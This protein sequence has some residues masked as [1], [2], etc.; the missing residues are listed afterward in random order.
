MRS[1]PKRLLV[2]LSISIFMVS[3][4]FLFGPLNVY[5]GNITEFSV[6]LITTLSFF[7]IPALILVFVS[8][9]VGLL[10]PEKLYS[11]Y[12]S[13]LFMFGVMIWLQ[14]NVL[15]WDYGL[16]DGQGI[17]WTKNGW[18]GWVD[19]SFWVSLFI[20]A[21]VFYR[22]IGKIAPLASTVMI[23]LQLGSSVFMGIQNPQ[24]WLDQKKT[25]VAM[26]PPEE[27]FEFSSQKNVIHIILDAFQSDIFQEIIDDQTD[28]YYNELQGFTFFK[29]ITGS[30]PTTRVSIPAIFSGQVY[31]NDIPMPDFIETV[32]SGK[33][34]SNVLYDH[35]YEVDF[36][37]CSEAGKGF[38]L[39]NEYGIPVPYGATRHY[40]EK[41]NSA[42]MA[43]LV[44][45]RS[46]PHFFKKHIY[47]NQKWLIQ[48]L[49][50]GETPYFYFA[51][52]AFLQDLIDN[53]SIARKKPVYKFMHL[54]TT[55][56]PILVDENCRFAGK[57]LPSTRENTII[58]QRCA[59]NHMLEFFNELKRKGIYESSLIILQADHGAGRMV[60]M[61]NMDKHKNDEY[62]NNKKQFAGIVGSALPLMAVKLSRGKGK[63]RISSAQVALTD[64]PATISS[65]LN[66]EENFGGR[67]MFEV[68]PHLTRERRFY[69]Y[70]WLNKGWQDD[71][72]TRLDEFIIKGSV[73]DRSSWQSG[74]I[75]FS[76]EASF[77]TKKI[78]F[79]T[80][81]SCCFKRS[82]WSVDEKSPEAGY[83]YNW[84][85][86]NSASINLSLPK[87]EG[88]LLTA[89]LTSLPLNIPQQ[90]N[91][92][93]DGHELGSWEVTAPPWNLTKY[94]IIIGPDP[95]RP[96]VSVVEFTFSKHRI[97]K[98]DERT[99]AAQFESVTLR[100]INPYK[101]GSTIRFGTN[102]NI[103]SYQTKGWNRPEKDFTWSTGKNSSLDILINRHK[104]STIILKASMKAFL[105][106]GKVDR[107]TVNILI[108]GKKAGEWIITKPGFQEQIL[109]IPNHL[110]TNHNKV[111]IITFNTP[112]ATSPARIGFNKDKRILG[113]ALR[114]IELI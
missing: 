36:V 59:L 90:I 74:L 82:G 29:E 41:I 112:D 37:S 47:N 108:N 76:P 25:S 77:D 26:S 23:L 13:M 92:K 38:R 49:L 113:I 101:W 97:P 69:F 22:Q 79:G 20:M 78:D 27:I 95:Q 67:S 91:V 51:H 68:D 11:Y 71:Y 88:V 45:F 63:L 9:G 53:C 84:A 50:A 15:V 80:T 4:F 56:Y 58:Q 62:I 110:F 5:Q 75:F 21:I 14:G 114:S 7:L 104:S 66:L 107:Q 98:G 96:A 30:F 105:V 43:D 3:G 64:L 32:M 60:E 35:G 103:Q 48:P 31:H 1:L 24:V 81:E 55:H 87:D 40:Y 46:A 28:Y 94:D 8:C 17:D 39:S 12:V 93:V 16:L 10:L 89:N 70:K 86:G 111:A 106:P 83:T 102:G 100:K 73:F 72:F 18:R 44:L 109:K 33:T 57:V 2:L 34:I 54:L 6:S 65:V 52:R 61:I 85:L 99:L 42:L 19:G